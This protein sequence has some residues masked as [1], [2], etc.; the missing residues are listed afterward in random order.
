MLS[1]ILSGVTLAA[2]LAGPCPASPLTTA[3]VIAEVEEVMIGSD[4]SLAELR[5]LS[6]QSGRVPR[7]TPLGFYAAD[8]RDLTTIAVGNESNDVCLGPVKVDLVVQLANRQVQIASDLQADACRLDVTVAHYQRHADA[9]AA[10]VTRFIPVLTERFAA[11]PLP[12][13]VAAIGRASPD[14]VELVV[15]MKRVAEPLL[16]EMT[17]AQRAAIEAVDTPEEIARLETACGSGT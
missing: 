6:Q 10:V 15:A 1:T 12:S 7:H 2:V 8:T 13:L 9:D 17:A 14:N 5:Q 4:Y 3:R 16:G 11:T